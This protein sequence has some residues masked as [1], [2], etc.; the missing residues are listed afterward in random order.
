MAAFAAVALLIAVALYAAGHT[1]PAFIA[2]MIGS[3]F[4]GL[5]LGA[6]IR[7]H[8]ERGNAGGRAR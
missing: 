8:R 3:A 2:W 7:L 6:T 4:V 5:W 1:V